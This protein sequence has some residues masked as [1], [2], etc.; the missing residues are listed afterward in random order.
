M[1]YPEEDVV[2]EGEINSFIHPLEIAVSR[3]TTI[4]SIKLAKNF[5]L[6]FVDAL[7]V[8]ICFIFSYFQSYVTEITKIDQI[9]DNTRHRAAN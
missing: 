8:F 1:L 2:H 7:T 5:G 9:P 3:R 4:Y 6:R